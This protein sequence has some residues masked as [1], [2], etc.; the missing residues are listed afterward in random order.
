MAR[1]ATGTLVPPKNEDSAWAIRFS[2]YGTRRYE[3][4]GNAED[5]W[6][7][8]KAEAALRHTLADVERGIWKPREPQTSEAPLEVPTFHQFASEWFEDAEAGWSDR[9]KVDYRWRLS[10]HLLP[11]FAGHRLDAIT[12]EGVD[13]YR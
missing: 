8:A 4:L 1:K 6:N 7:R 11:Y 10:N 5:G 2:A 12:V 13:R 9:T 3:A